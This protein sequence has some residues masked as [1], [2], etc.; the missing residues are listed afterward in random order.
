VTLGARF[1]EKHFTDDKS[2][3]GPDHGFSLDPHDWKSMV[4][5]TRILEKSLGDG[6]K[7]VEENE[8]DAQIVQRRALRFATELSKGHVI[9]QAD[10]IA[11]RPIP[12][13]GISPMDVELVLGK[14]L[15]RQVEADELVTFEK[16]DD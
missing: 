13:T 8:R 16:L 14:K 4:E 12:E 11:L 3:L 9:K 5:D 15:A 6:V 2:R 7:K 1:I 10:L